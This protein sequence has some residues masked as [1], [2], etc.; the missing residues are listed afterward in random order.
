[1]SIF[2]V[3]Y[4]S[5]YFRISG[6]SSKVMALV[7][8]TAGQIHTVQKLF[9]SSFP[10]FW[11]APLP[12]LYSFNKCLLSTYYGIENMVVN[13]K[14]EFLPSWSQ[15]LDFYKTHGKKETTEC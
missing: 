10:V 8:G 15:S 4:F 14:S 7:K 12:S 2:S 1:M 6:A 11:P 3:I 5:N 9:F 13:K